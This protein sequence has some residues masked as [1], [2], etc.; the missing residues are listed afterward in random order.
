[1]LE[2]SSEEHPEAVVQALTVEQALVNMQSDDLSL[3]YYAAWW[4]GKFRISEP[5]AVDALIVALEDEADRT[6]LGDTLC[7]A[8]LLGRWVNWAISEQ[9]QG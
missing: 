9:C 7:V 3:R 2:S 6:E 5:S 4:L 8:M 1:M